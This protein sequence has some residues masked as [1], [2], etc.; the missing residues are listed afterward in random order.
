[1]TVSGRHAMARTTGIRR[2]GRW[3]RHEGHPRQTGQA[4][5]G[6]PPGR[7]RE[8]HRG[9]AR[10]RKIDGKRAHRTAA[11]QGFLRGVRHVR[12]APLHRL[13]HGEAEDPRR[14]R[15]DRL[16][17]HQRPRG[18]SLLQGLYRVWRFAVG[19]ACPEDH[20]GTGHGAEGARAHHRPVR[21]RR[22]PHP[23]RRRGAGWLRRGVQAQRHRLRRHSPDQRHHGP[24]RRRRRLFAGDDRFHLHGARH[25]L[26]VRH[27]SG[28][29]EDRH[30]RGGHRG[31]TRRRERAHHQVERRRRR[32]RERR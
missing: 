12:G 11:R 19:G 17:H 24:L 14:R 6:G 1:M 27:R 30:Q 2:A 15:R 22:R 26:H 7:R 23:G 3:K 9:P 16:G 28:R 31:R 29:G 20:E 21:R 25:L 13:R 18:L 4:A 32:L 8:A 10:A 5:G